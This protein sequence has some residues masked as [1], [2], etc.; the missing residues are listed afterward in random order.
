[1]RARKF[2]QKRTWGRNVFVERLERARI[3]QLGF[4]RQVVCGYSRSESTESDRDRYSVRSNRLAIGFQ[5]A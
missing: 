1:M 2:D 3:A 4:F 5:C